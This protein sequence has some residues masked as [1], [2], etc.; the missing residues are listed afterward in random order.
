MTSIALASLAGCAADRGGTEADTEGN[1]EGIEQPTATVLLDG[2]DAD[3]LIALLGRA[4]VEPIYGF[5][6]PNWS[7]RVGC[8]L[9]NGASATCALDPAIRP[10]GG[11]D[12]RRAIE[13]L[14]KAGVE[15]IS[16][17]VGVTWTTRVSC[18]RING[19]TP[20]CNVQAAAS[21]P[22][23]DPKPAEE[24]RLHGEEAARLIDYL[25]EVGVESIRGVAG[26]TWSASVSCSLING[27]SGF[28]NFD[29]ASERLEGDAVNQVIGLLEKAGVRRVYGFAGPIWTAKA[30]CTL[31]NGASPLCNVTQ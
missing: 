14:E 22:D 8:T 15:S 6:G 4:G 2:E 19:T 16:G 7:A 29:P 3:D 27:A 13:L 31:L 5:A 30:S 11:A 9:V 18:N 21:Q 25:D 12:A 20:M 1:L 17:V 23:P 10:L 26:L 24:G 28:C